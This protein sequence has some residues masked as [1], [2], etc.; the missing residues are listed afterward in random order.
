MAG[1]ALNTTASP[2]SHGLAAGAT[3]T[4]QYIVYIHILHL[5]QLN[6]WLSCLCCVGPHPSCSGLFLCSIE[7][8]KWPQV[9][10]VRGLCTT[11]CNAWIGGASSAIDVAPWPVAANCTR[12][13]R[14]RPWLPADCVPD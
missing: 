10:C 2:A 4:A 1:Q 12:A 14:L 5:Q 6:F 8:W 13:G 9:H 7:R 11:G 3:D